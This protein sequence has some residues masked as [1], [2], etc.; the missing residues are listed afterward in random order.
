MSEWSCMKFDNFIASADV[1][2]N[3][4]GRD[5]RHTTKLSLV[6]FSQQLQVE[7]GEHSSLL[8]GRMTQLLLTRITWAKFVTGNFLL[9][10]LILSA[11]SR[12][13]RFYHVPPI[14][15]TQYHPPHL[16]VSIP[17]NSSFSPGPAPDSCLVGRGL[18]APGS[19][20]NAS[21]PGPLQL[22]R[23]AWLDQGV[24]FNQKHK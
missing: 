16:L 12:L 22:L 21:C 18:S 19:L 9:P 24:A 7:Q 8:A 3:R 2:R 10:S 20:Q 14:S 17:F 5:A 4:K 15:K 6:W 13:Q 1:Q 23:P 11:H